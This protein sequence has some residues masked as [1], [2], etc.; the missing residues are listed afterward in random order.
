MQIKQTDIQTLAYGRN[1]EAVIISFE[2]ALELRKAGRAF[3]HKPESLKHLQKP[4]R[5][6]DFGPEAA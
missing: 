4:L 2:K 5:G 3:V 1:G 6:D